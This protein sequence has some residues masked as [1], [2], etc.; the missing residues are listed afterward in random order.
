MK[1]L[2]LILPILFLTSCST[3]V[4]PVP[5][6]PGYTGPVVYQENPALSNALYTV[7]Q[8]A[9]AA[10]APWGTAAAGLVSLTSLLLAGYVSHKNSTVANNA[11]AS[12]G[13]PPPPKV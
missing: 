7:G 2:F 11:I 4:K 1:N 5:Q 3:L 10:P 6:A 13:T 8:V 9:Q 12:T